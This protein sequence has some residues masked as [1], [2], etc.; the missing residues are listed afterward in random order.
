MEGRGGGEAQGVA[1]PK[2]QVWS[3]L[4]I[5][6]GLPNGAYIFIPKIQIWTFLVCCTH[7]NL[8]T[9]TRVFELLL[10]TF[11]AKKT[12]KSLLISI[13]GKV[14]YHIGTFLQ[15]STK[16]LSQNRAEKIRPFFS[17]CLLKI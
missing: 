10:Q 15:G 9:R 12:S 11:W 6:S 1:D 17:T 16:P 2:K 14:I 4:Y 3:L 5:Y 13:L 8:S 7:R